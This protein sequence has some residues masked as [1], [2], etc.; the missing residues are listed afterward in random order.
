MVKVD[1]V[2]LKIIQPSANENHLVGEEVKFTAKI[3]PQNKHDIY[4]SQIQWTVS[5]GSATPSTGTGEEFK[6]IATSQGAF[7]VNALVTI[8][9]TVSEDSVS[10][11]TIIPQV[12]SVSFVYDHPLFDHFLNQP[13]SDPVWDKNISGPMYKNEPAAYTKGSNAQARLKITHLKDLTS[14]TVVQVRGV[15]VASDDENFF[16]ESMIF[17]QHWPVMSSPVLKS[18]PLYQ[19]VNFY[20]TLDVNWQYRVRK[21]DGTFPDWNSPYVI[22]MNQSNHK[23]YTTYDS[24]Q[25]PMLPCWKEVIDRATFYAANAIT[26]KDIRSKITVSINQSGFTYDG[27][28]SHTTGYDLLHLSNRNLPVGV[29]RG[30]LDDTWVDCRDCSN[31]FSVLCKSIGDNPKS[32]TIHGPFYYNAIKPI[33]AFDYTEAGENRWNFHQVGYQNVYDPC[34]TV[35]GI[36]PQD[37][38]F[39]M[40]ET[41]LYYKPNGGKFHPGA[42]FDCDV[43]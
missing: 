21:L 43:D 15:K 6:T 24:P 23:I 14:S 37:M 25:P 13:I 27:S 32:L 16:P 8:V 39:N 3:S 2:A 42:P 11:E 33:G 22:T 19:S 12:T 29:T 9:G 31:Y 28:K 4:K 18:S 5:A 26:Q 10:I 30:L 17:P 36:I 20:D 1:T 38:D 35:N 34:V 41:Y 7:S 40:Y